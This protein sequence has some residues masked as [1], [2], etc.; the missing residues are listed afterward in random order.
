MAN[1]VIL[2]LPGEPGL[3]VVDLDA[4]TV[5][6][7]DVPTSGALA[8]ADSIRKAGGTVVKGVGLAVAVASAEA[9]FSGV[10]DA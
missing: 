2:G 7:L 9:A 3:Y 4:R 8:S 5:E 6:P 1:T 10:F